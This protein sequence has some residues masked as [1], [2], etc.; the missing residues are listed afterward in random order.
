[1]EWVSD[2]ELDYLGQFGLEREPFNEYAEGSAFFQDALISQRL[3]MLQHFS[4]YSDLMLLVT[5]EFGAGKSTL[6]R[7]FSAQLDND[8]QVSQVSAS[9]TMDRESMLLALGK[10]FGMP[11]ILD[12][13]QNAFSKQLQSL[14]GS[15]EAGLFIIDDA[16]LLPTDTLLYVMELAE[17]RGRQGKLLRVLLFAEPSIEQLLAE[18]ALAKLGERISHSLDVPPM[19][20]ERCEAYIQHRLA[21]AGYDGEPIFSK[22]MVRKICKASRGN[23]KRIN[24]L[25]TESL[26]EA[27]NRPVDEGTSVKRAYT[28]VILSVLILSIATA[29]YLYRGEIFPPHTQS[30][31]GETGRTVTLPLKGNSDPAPT[32]KGWSETDSGQTH[33]DTPVT[34]T[35]IDPSP[36]SPAEAPTTTALLKTDTVATATSHMAS[37]GPDEGET[38]APPVIKQVMPSPVAGSSRRQSITIKGSGFHKGAKL[39]V[40]WT[41][42]AIHLKP[43]QV[44]WVS[45]EEISFRVIT[46]TQA[47]TWTVRVNN[48]DKLGSNVYSF[49]VVPPQDPVRQQ[50]VVA[51]NET[52]TDDWLQAR[53]GQNYT[54]QL[55]ASR[56]PKAVAAFIDQHALKQAHEVQLMKQGQRWHY[57]VYGDY[58]SRIEADTVAAELG[59]RLPGVKPWVRNMASLQQVMLQGQLRGAG[60]I[61]QQANSAYSLQ[62]VAGSAR[63]TIVAFV[64]KHQLTGSAA[65][66][67]T[68][69]NGKPWYVLI[70]GVYADQ[71]QAKAAVAQ[72]PE[73]VR[74]LKPWSRS[75]ASIKTDLK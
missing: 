68:Q 39:T 34:N 17:I 25:A 70:Y 54:I 43:W 66:Y 73:S 31:A 56:N 28:V 60:W 13:D 5:G 24:E 62:L 6:K 29:L 40:G 23:P 36:I 71:A 65:V 16:H 15:D 59:A 14:L 42:K 18:P 4:R 20:A 64:G 50:T 57:L 26:L 48:P 37:K 21:S 74:K 30:A 11:P 7:H 49:Q 53:S 69:R 58:S 8:I 27:V 1:M 61:R 63:D 33:V 75:F 19:E 22:A 10:G 12:G 41:G 35:E 52:V 51:K 45:S 46:G 47:D 72:L 44:T 9:S 67:P 32:L 2:E 38:V 55:L 3:G